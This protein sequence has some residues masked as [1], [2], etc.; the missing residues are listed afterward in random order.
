MED[1]QKKKGSGRRELLRSLRLLCKGLSQE[2]HRNLEG[3][4]SQN[5][6]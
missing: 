4:H 6:I 5:L 3:D 1:P 2:C